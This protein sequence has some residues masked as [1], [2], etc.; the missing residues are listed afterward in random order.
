MSNALDHVV[1]NTRFEM[2]EAARL[3]EGLGFQLTP[4]GFHPTL[5]SINHLMVFK[6]DYLELI[7]LPRDGKIIRQELIDSPIGLNG[8][9]FAST[10]AARTRED[11][12]S[13]GFE[14]QPVQHFARPLMI[15]GTGHEARFSAVRLALD[16]FAA[17]RLYFCQHHTPELIWRPEWM[18]HPN[19]VTDIVELTIASADPAATRTDYE[20]L[21]RIG[22]DFALT[23]VDAD[24]LRERFGELAP[25]ALARP[26]QF[27]AVT[28]RS[29]DPQF[30]ADR[31][32]ALGLPH[33]EAGGRVVVA[34]PALASLIEFIA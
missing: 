23:V 3:M 1:I 24:A 28:L 29:R 27:A 16:S 21:G 18:D 31:A 14:A 5:G 19:G 33:H 26:E 15:D 2:D 32:A 12:V 13:H 22:G 4:R 10:D 17:G 25:F 7:G 20:R 34:L 6:R 11:V 9:V 8:L 30:A